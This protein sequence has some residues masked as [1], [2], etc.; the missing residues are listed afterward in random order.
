MSEAII[1]AAF[2]FDLLGQESGVERAGPGSAPTAFRIWKAGLTRTDKGDSIFN[3]AAAERLMA[4]QAARGNLYSIDVDHMSLSETAPPEYHKAVGWHRLEVRRDENG[5]PELWACDVQWVPEIKAGLEKDP[6]EWRYFSPAYAV[7]TETREVTRYANTALTNNPATW[8]VT[9]LASIAAAGKASM[10]LSELAAALRA[11]ADGDGEDAK[12]A[13]A[14]CAILDGDK[15]GGDKEAKKTS[16]GADDKKDDGENKEA[17]K[18][19]EGADDKD[20]DKETKVAASN[21]DLVKRVHELEVTIATDKERNEIKE[22]LATRPDFSKE[23]RATLAVSP[24]KVVRDAVKNWKR[25]S[26]AE[27]PTEDVQA[28]RGEGQKDGKSSRLPAEQKKELDI[29]MGLRRPDDM[30]KH[31]AIHASFGAM[32]RDDAEAFVT[33]KKE[34]V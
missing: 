6:P 22:L 20:E 13:K 10:K 5:D 25:G 34:A 18:A 17:K 2:A 23:V 8:R 14:L 7:H 24:I 26:A 27:V 30:I 21:I 4:D 29:R 9:A 19:S 15:D 33:A 12:T 1:R 28:T 3:E 31:T 11:M 16:E 32:T